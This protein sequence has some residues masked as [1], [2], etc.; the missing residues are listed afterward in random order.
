MYIHC[1]ACFWFKVI[2]IDSQWIPPI[3]YNDYTLMTFW[4]GN[5]YVYQ[6]FLCVYY[7]VLTIGGNEM[8]PTTTSEC[9]MIS[10]LG[11]AASII[12]A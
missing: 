3:N 8:G 9:I 10:F 2:L 5:D 1:M 7:V 4:T 6:Y 11:I 12:N